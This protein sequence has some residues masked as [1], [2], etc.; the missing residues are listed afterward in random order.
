MNHS[1]PPPSL[2]RADAQAAGPLNQLLFSGPGK[3]KLDVDVLTGFFEE[4]NFFLSFDF[5]EKHDAS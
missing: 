3:K 2:P 4:R 1:S 5:F